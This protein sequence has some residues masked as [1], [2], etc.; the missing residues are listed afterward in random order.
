[1]AEV[2]FEAWLDRTNAIEVATPVY[3][4]TVT[5]I[6]FT[7]ID[8]DRDAVDLTS[9]AVQFAANRV[10]DDTELFDV[11]CSLVIAASGT[12]RAALT[13]VNL[14]SAGEILGELRLYSGGDPAGDCTDRIQFRFKIVEA[15]G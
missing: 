5:N 2:A 11:A 4:S 9:Y 7:V 6:N 8:A 13:A 3:Q 12:C 15:V 10:S 14:A 1:M